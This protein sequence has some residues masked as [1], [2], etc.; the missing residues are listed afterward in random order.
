MTKADFIWLCN[1]HTIDPSIALE[2]E[3]VQD[4]LKQHKG[5]VIQQ[6]ALSQYLTNNY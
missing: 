2:D 5:S 4:I 6:L 3:R 1:E